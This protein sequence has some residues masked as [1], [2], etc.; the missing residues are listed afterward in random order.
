MLLHVSVYDSYLSLA[1]VRI[2]KSS[3]KIR[4]YKLCSGVAAYCVVINCA[5]V[6]Q[7]TML[8]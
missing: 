1:K 2:V 8:L 4:R 5:V 3:I 7:H 6:W